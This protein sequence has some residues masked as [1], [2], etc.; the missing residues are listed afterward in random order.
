MIDVFTVCWRAPEGKHNDRAM[1]T[2]YQMKTNANAWLANITVSH[3]NALLHGNGVF[4]NEP[5]KGF[6]GVNILAFRF[7][8]HF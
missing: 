3:V 1:I 4:W 8:L 5:A 7:N 6:L 2:L